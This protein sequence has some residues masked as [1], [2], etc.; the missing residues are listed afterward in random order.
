MLKDKN[1]LIITAG[2]EVV[3]N[4][5]VHDFF[6]PSLKQDG[7]EVRYLN[8]RLLRENDRAKSFLEYLIWAEN[9]NALIIG[10][11]R[12]HWLNDS[13]K[14]RLSLSQLVKINYIIDSEMDWE[15]S[16]YM[17]EIFDLTAVSMKRTYDILIGKYKKIVYIP[18]GF[19][20]KG[21]KLKSREDSF[22]FFASPTLGRLR[23]LCHLKKN[24]VPVSSNIS[25]KDDCNIFPS[26]IVRPEMSISSESDVLNLRKNILIGSIWTKLIPKISYKYSYIDSKDYE[27]VMTQY[28]F[29]IGF[30]DYR[31]TGIVSKAYV[32]YRLRDV[33][34][35]SAGCIHLTRKSEDIQQYIDK[36]LIIYTYNNSESIV[37]AAK[38]MM[39]LNK[40]E[41]LEIQKNNYCVIEENTWLKNIEKALIGVDSIV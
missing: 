28:W 1:I 9:N 7:V 24:K 32:H 35:I 39:S 10:M 33:E 11:L 20:S 4:N 25:I 2:K 8:F 38:E 19:Y 26:K 22:S 30:N 36:G 40:S 21:M 3:T 5:W 31:N 27:K 37:C 16:K 15:K 17:Y 41:R 23:Y 14:E 18:F 12:D 13:E 34:C 6:I 29:S